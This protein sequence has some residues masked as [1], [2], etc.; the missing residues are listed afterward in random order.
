[1]GRVVEL[2]YNKSIFS[3]AFNPSQFYF[4]PWDLEKKGPSVFFGY[5]IRTLLI[6]EKETDWGV[7][8]PPASPNWMQEDQEEKSSLGRLPSAKSGTKRPE[9]GNLEY[10]P[11]C[12]YLAAHQRSPPTFRERLGLR[13]STYQSQMLVVC[14]PQLQR[15]EL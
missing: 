10:S 12:L 5:I 6:F 14:V 8:G 13:H 9:L 3:K 11:A 15:P 1:M 2:D 4:N 7:L